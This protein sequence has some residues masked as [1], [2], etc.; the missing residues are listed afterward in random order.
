MVGC[1]SLLLVVVVLIFAARLASIS[2]PSNDSAN[3]A[4]GGVGNDVFE[5]TAIQDAGDADKIATVLNDQIAAWNRDDLKAFMATYWNSPDLT[6][7]AGGQTTRGWQATM[8]RYAGRYPV[9]NMG[10]LN[11]DGLE[12]SLLG[13][14]AA[15]VL[16]NWHLEQDSEK[17]DG[18]FTLVL[19]RIEG[20]W[21]IVHDH[22]SSLEKK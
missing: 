15:L 8:D 16:G 1:R 7:S 10:Q 4:S 2:P 22:S 13:A 20:K 14:D 9:G 21:L 3:G 12:I 11:F 5:N 17:M 6:F 19:R 18:N